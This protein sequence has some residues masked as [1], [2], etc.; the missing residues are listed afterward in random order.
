VYGCSIPVN[1]GRR[2]WGR[3]ADAEEAVLKRPKGLRDTASGNC[4]LP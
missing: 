3:R 2:P 1:P 4:R